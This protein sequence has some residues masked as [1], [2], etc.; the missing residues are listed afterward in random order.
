VSGLGPAQGH[1]AVRGQGR[2]VALAVAII[3][4]LVGCGAILIV[5]GVARGWRTAAALDEMSEADFDY[6][7]LLDSELEAPEDDDV[8]SR[9]P[10]DD[11]V[12]PEPGRK[13]A[14]RT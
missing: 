7:D 12:P 3:V 4:F 2:I 13:A 1:E 11:G 5:T 6:A 8:L 14:S 9:A 10:E